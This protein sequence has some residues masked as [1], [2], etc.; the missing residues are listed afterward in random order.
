[1]R[2][3]LSDSRSGRSVVEAPLLELDAIGVVFNRR[4]IGSRLRSRAGSVHALRG[5]SLCLRRGESVGV[6]GE[7]GSGKS[8]L[9]AIAIGTLQPTSGR[10]L[11]EG[12]PLNEL[13][14]ADFRSTRRRLQIVLQNPYGSL[15]PWITVGD[16][17][18]EALLVH[19]RVPKQAVTGRVGEL[20]ELV[21]L[22]PAH[23]QRY[24]KEFS[25]GQRQR[26]A[27]AR[28]LALE[29]D[30][31]VCDEVTSGLDVSVRGQ[32]VNLL[33]DLRAQTGVSYLF[34]THDLPVARAISDRIVVM[35]DGEVVE[36]G[37]AAD[38]MDRPRH[39]YTRALLQS[40]LHLPGARSGD[41]VG[42]DGRRG[43]T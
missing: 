8:T 22:S 23:A 19:G 24:P 5:V 21:G 13:I 39:P 34:I 30:L 12:K 31:L 27:I 41:E 43:P 25:G 15:T 17:L 33:G 7:S 38:V 10:V 29:P 14:G 36:A 1:V 28:A 3:P 42:A 18:R 40:R 2:V 32:I 20:L 35:Q 6:V 4:G 26:L 11:V 16:A 37:S 9:G